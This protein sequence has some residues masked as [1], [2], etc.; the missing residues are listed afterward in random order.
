MLPT[1][2]AT[3]LFCDEAALMRMTN[4]A[5]VI[6]RLDKC[7]AANAAYW[8]FKVGLRTWESITCLAATHM[9]HDNT[10]YAAPDRDLVRIVCT[11]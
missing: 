11:T 4:T 9:L 5:C 1:C 3:S 10:C 7:P 8:A 2:F 6:A